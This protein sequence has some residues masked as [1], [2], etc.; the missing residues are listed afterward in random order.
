MNEE[1]RPKSSDKY[2]LS[3]KESVYLLRKNI[4]ELV[5]NAG[6]FDGEVYIHVKH[7]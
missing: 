7:G 4:M 3:L 1:K 5:Y 2:Q 6:Q